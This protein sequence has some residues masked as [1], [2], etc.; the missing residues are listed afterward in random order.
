MINESNLLLTH[1]ERTELLECLLDMGEILL[2]NGAE[3]SRVEDALVRTGKAYGAKHV[4][5]FVI[6]SIIILSIEFDDLDALT[7]TRRI[8]SSTGTYFHKIAEINSLSRK[9]CR[10][11]V[12]LPEFRSS[13][14]EIAAM[15]KNDNLVTAGGVIAAGSF[16]VFFGGTFI[17]GIAASLFAVMITVLQNKLGSTQ[18]NTSASNLLV[19]L[20]TGLCVGFLGKSFAFLHVD[21]ILI[22]DIMLLVPGLAMTNSVRNILV[23][24]TISGVIRLIESFIWALAL[25]G[26]I[27][28]AMIIV[29]TVIKS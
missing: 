13:L 22:G 26:G 6:T 21:K 25:A 29:E 16:A 28:T 7:E 1:E 20:I 23:G 11:R 14:N 5:A 17:D 9:I 24:N 4:D 18:V 8:Y 19:S 2:E 12:Y 3:I 27:M 10:E 15:A